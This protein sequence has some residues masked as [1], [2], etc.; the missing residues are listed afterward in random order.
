MKE[1]GCAVVQM[2]GEDEM[3]IGGTPIMENEETTGL[4][5]GDCEKVPATVKDTT[6]GAMYDMG[7]S[8]GHRLQIFKGVCLRWRLVS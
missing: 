6:Q 3:G 8:G 7:I 5:K 4:K 2:P 1:D